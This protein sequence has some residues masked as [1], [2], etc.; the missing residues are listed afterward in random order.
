LIYRIGE[1][2]YG[3]ERDEGGDVVLA[4]ESESCDSRIHVVGYL[5]LTRRNKKSKKNLRDATRAAGREHLGRERKRNPEKTGCILWGFYTQ[6]DRSPRYGQGPRCYV[7]CVSSY[8]FRARTQTRERRY[9][10]MSDDEPDRAVRL[11]LQVS[12]TA[13]QP[14]EAASAQNTASSNINLNCRQA[15]N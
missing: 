2:V 9:P 3:E 14:H 11:P 4:D 13:C 5:R 10:S 12:L 7:T 8:A 15:H 1:D 6:N